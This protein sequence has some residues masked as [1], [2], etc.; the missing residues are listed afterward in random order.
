MS[1]LPEEDLKA[2]IS[3]NLA[4]MIDFLFLMLVFFASLAISRVMT[5]DTEIQLAKLQP[6]VPQQSRH[7][8]ERDLPQKVV[9]LSIA[10]NGQYRWITQVRDYEIST[11]A[12]VVQEL[13]SQYQQGQLPRD[14]RRTQVF[15]K[16]DREARW[17]PIVDLIFAVRRAGFQIFPLYEPDLAQANA[18]SN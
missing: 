1:F 14:K 4:P 6:E 18:S 2:R 13:Q 17:Q 10:A 8:K 11:P 7:R 15:V 12:G 5:L 16:I 9:S 3:L